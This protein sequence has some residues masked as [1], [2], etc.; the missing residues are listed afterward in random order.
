MGREQYDSFLFD[1]AITKMVQMEQF[2]QWL[3]K[4]FFLNHWLHGEYDFI[5]QDNFYI[6][7]YQLMTE[8]LDHLNKVINS[9]EENQS[10]FSSKLIW[11]NE[12]RDGLFELKAKLSSEEFD[13]IEYKRHNVCH[14][15][16]NHYTPKL[17][18][19]GTIKNERKGKNLK[20]QENEFISIIRIHGSDKGFDI[21]LTQKLY[22]IIVE[23]YNKLKQ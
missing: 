8:G 10:K 7:F 13:F 9:L 20:S 6:V 22:P 1:F 3:R 11:Y 5:Y 16:Q 2:A 23:I 14:I 21:Y 15:F 12:L 19:N 18:N 17:L 4:F